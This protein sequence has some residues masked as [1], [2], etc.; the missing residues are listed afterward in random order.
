MRLCEN[1]NLYLR[2]ELETWFGT[3]DNFKPSMWQIKLRYIP[4]KSDKL[5]MNL[6]FEMSKKNV[7]FL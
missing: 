7:R 1:A 3:F 6:M 4:W 5:N 2:A